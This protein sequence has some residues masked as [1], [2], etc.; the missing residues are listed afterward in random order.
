MGLKAVKP[1]LLDL[2]GFGVGLF[3][4]VS[5]FPLIFRRKRA[6]A[7]ILRNQRR[8]LGSSFGDWMASRTDASGNVLIAVGIGWLL[9]GGVIAAVSLT[10]MGVKL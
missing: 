10:N 7:K 4:V 1:D 5:A 8:A 9:L 3:F 6:L 2:F